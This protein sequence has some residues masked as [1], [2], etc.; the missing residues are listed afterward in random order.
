[1][2]RIFVCLAVALMVALGP[3]STVYALSDAEYKKMFQTSDDF[4]ITDMELTDT[5]KH[6][7][8]QHKGQAKK[9]LLQEQRAWL[10]YGRDATAK[11]YMNTGMS[12]V[13]AYTRAIGDR[14]E[15]LKE[16]LPGYRNMTPE[17]KLF[18]SRVARDMYQEQLQAS[19]RPKVVQ[20]CGIVEYVEGLPGLVNLVRMRDLQ[21]NDLGNFFDSDEAPDRG[22]SECSRV[23]RKG[24]LICFD[25]YKETPNNMGYDKL[26]IKDPTMRWIKNCCMPD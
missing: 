9:D 6:V 26:G 12:K 14:V 21:G 3:V 8:D 20:V 18:A 11:A 5:W 22:Y 2:K 24:E 19:R 13:D 4:A 10:K 7:Y 1:M 16:K 17:E 25:V 23:A 15:E